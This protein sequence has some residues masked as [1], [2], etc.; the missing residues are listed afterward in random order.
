MDSVL[1]SDWLT[2][3]HLIIWS[4]DAIRIVNERGERT[5][6]AISFWMTSELLKGLPFL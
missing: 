4:A 3:A 5:W 2:G 6:K 1:P